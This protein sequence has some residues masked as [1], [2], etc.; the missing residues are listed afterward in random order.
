MG[1]LPDFF[2]EKTTKIII[3]K[4]FKRNMLTIFIFSSFFRVRTTRLTN[5]SISSSHSAMSTRE[6]DSFVVKSYFVV[7]FLSFFFFKI[8]LL[9]I[10]KRYK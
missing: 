7:D 10:L 8:E 1:F 5:N 9:S 2:S 3:F 6:S 4:I